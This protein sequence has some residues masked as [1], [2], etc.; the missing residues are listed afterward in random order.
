MTRWLAL[1]LVVVAGVAVVAVR[2]VFARTNLVIIV[3]DTLRAD[4]VG[5]MSGGTTADALPPDS[6]PTTPNIDRYAR[7]SYTFRRAWS[8]GA[9]TLASYMSYMSSTHV[10]THGL[11]GNLGPA[12]ICDWDDLKMLPE[13]LT[14]AGFTADAWVANA[15]LHPK[16]G[17]PRGFQTWNGAPVGEADGRPSRIRST[18]DADV[19]LAADQA[20]SE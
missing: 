8:Q 9:Y 13:V 5:A 15:H 14:E 16:K 19:V 18:L 12:G 1:A 17:F 6:P 4:H 2:P 20:F 7:S 10:R 3:V 11:D